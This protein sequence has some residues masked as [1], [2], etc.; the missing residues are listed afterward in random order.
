MDYEQ[1]KKIQQLRIFQA[2]INSHLNALSDKG[3]A[4]NT[5]DAKVLEYLQKLSNFINQSAGKTGSL[6]TAPKFNAQA[7][8]QDSSAYRRLKDINA[9]AGMLLQFEK[10][11]LIKL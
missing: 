2:V 11:Q 3:S 9:N 4:A 8:D 5:D 7:I 10:S 1:R 6:S